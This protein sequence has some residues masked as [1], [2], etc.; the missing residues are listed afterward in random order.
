M[1]AATL[2][3]ILSSQHGMSVTY[4]PGPM[5]VGLQ[6]ANGKP[7]QRQEDEVTS[8][9]VRGN[10]G[11]LRMAFSNCPALIL[12][13]TQSCDLSVLQSHPFLIPSHLPLIPPR[14]ESDYFLCLILQRL[15][16]RN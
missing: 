1:V 12:F 8:A 11:K 15:R 13:P 10:A 16:L 3:V 9:E 14:A 6:A 5:R 4:C 2:R 7:H